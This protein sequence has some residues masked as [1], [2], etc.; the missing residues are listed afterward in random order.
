MK[1]IEAYINN[2]V[3]AL[4][5]DKGISQ[6]AFGDNL[7]LSQSFIRDC[8]NPYRETKYNLR[9]LNEIVKVFGCSF[10]YFFPDKAL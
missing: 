8:E 5:L 3:K 6:Q 2:R 10:S 9:H 7:N 4:R 1:P